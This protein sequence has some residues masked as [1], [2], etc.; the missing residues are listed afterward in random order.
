[1]AERDVSPGNL[2]FHLGVGSVVLIIVVVFAIFLGLNS[3]FI[4]DQTEESV[5][6][7][8]GKYSRTVG[9]G[10]NWKIPVLEKSFNVPTKIVQKEEFGFRT[11]NA[12]V[13]SR[14]SDKEYPNESRM[15]TG[16]LNIIDVEWVIQYRIEDPKA[17][18][19]NV[20]DSVR[21]DEI[22]MQRLDNRIK[23]IR[24]ISQTV[25]NQLVG[26]RTIFD[27]I[28][29]ERT[30]IETKGQELMNELLVKYGLGA[31]IQ[32]VQLQNI[33]PPLGT[34]Q[35][36]F[37]DV[38]IAQQDMN[39]LI[40]EGQEEYNKVI[41]KANGER[42]QIIQQAEGYKAKRINEAEGDV[43]R[44][45]A[46]LEEYRKSPRVTKTRLYYEMLEEVFENEKDID[47]I[48]ESLSN[49]IPIKNLGTNNKNNVEGVQ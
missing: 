33:V 16:D 47:L 46:M 43:A 8:L 41:P 3:F 45:K 2:P 26:D 36:A 9:P 25:M 27:V 30:M 21:T 31:K 20:D 13:D 18:L 23:T 40:N 5:V 32:Q 22:T 35:D 37:E 48:D 49:F 24:D 14:Y 39:R 19:F 17:W 15:L 34:V 38:N 4:V 11:E 1:M 6:L 10:M 7:F 12:G 29:S 42:D 28:G 44:F